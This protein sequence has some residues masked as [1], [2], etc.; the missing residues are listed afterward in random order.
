VPYIWALHDT[1]MPRCGLRA[2]V[3][4]AR[5]RGRLS[6][7]HAQLSSASI[8]PQPVSTAI[9]PCMLNTAVWRCSRRD[10]GKVAS[11]AFLL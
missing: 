5:T 4:Y 8:R 3:L 10:D 9:V 7:E 6:L 1:L 11:E 2:L